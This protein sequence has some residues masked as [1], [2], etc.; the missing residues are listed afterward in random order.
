MAR[1]LQPC[2]TPAAYQRHIRHSEVPCTACT[3]AEADRS[4]R[5]RA[6]IRDLQA[7]QAQRRADLAAAVYTDRRRRG[8]RISAAFR[9]EL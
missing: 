8:D 5:Y 4:A 2:G 7:Q 3:R 6:E 9:G 1:Q